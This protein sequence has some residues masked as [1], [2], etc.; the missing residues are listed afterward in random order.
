MCAENT[1]GIVFEWNII[2]PSYIPS[3]SNFL[4]H[5]SSFP[6][7]ITCSN[8]RYDLLSTLGAINFRE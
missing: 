5:F 2:V 7:K 8:R 6:Y 4:Y 3:V 1:K